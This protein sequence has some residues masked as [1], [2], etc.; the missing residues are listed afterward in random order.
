MISAMCLTGPIAF[1]PAEAFSQDRPVDVPETMVEAFEPEGIRVQPFILRPR[2][3]ADVRYDTNIYNQPNHTSD[4]VAV[5]RPSIRLSS[6]FSRHALEVRASAEGRRYFET[7][8]EN[9]NQW[10]VQADTKL[11]LAERYFISTTI[12]EARRIERRGTFGDQFA[13][14]EPVS[15]N[16]FGARLQFGRSGGIVDWRVDAATRKLTYHD[17]QLDGVT[18][19]QSSRD[20]RRDSL[21]AR[22]GYRSSPALG[23]FMRVSGN[24]LRYDVNPVRN[25]QGFSVLAG[26]DYEVS[27]LVNVEAGAGYVLQNSDDPSESDIKAVDFNLQATWTPTARTKFG[28]RVEREVERSPFENT[29][30]ILRTTFA[31]NASTAI[32]SRL[33]I[34]IEAG[35]VRNDYKGID[36]TDT[37]Y[38]AEATA[39]YQLT[40]HLAAFAGA[41]VRK[42]DGSGLGARSYDGASI[43]AGISFV[44]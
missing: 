28:L 16:E 18:L 24:R 21:A 33:L 9:S 4:T 40:P 43:R 14:D 31:A 10:S 41:G 42:Q 3:T 27:D 22:V 25:S 13:T 12:G 29:S 6:D 44:L 35:L 37:R 5:V 30:S 23:F 19:D 15:Y 2:V 8:A 17:A 20:V 11:D 38:F 1:L 36:R 7:G 34:G 39:R 32:G 26:I